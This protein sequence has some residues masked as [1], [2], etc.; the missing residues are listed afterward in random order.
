M[1]YARVLKRIKWDCA[2]AVDLTD[3]VVLAQPCC[4]ALPPKLA[5]ATDGGSPKVTRTRLPINTPSRDRP[6]PAHS[7]VKRLLD[8]T[9]RS[10]WII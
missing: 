6:A 2:F 4:D 10:T 7:D 8:T 5:I 9:A 3:V 1:L